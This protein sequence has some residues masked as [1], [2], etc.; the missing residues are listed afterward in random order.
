MFGKHRLIRSLTVITFILAPIMADRTIAATMRL[1]TKN[2]KSNDSSLERDSNSNLSREYNV[3]LFSKPAT[4]QR[5]INHEDNKGALSKQSDET[6]S[7]V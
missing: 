5:S 2:G 7:K 6:L 1:L 4:N 3:Q